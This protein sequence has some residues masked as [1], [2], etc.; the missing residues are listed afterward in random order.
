MVV[1]GSSAVTSGSSLAFSTNVRAVTMS[2]ISAPRH[3]AIADAGPVEKL[4][5]A[6]TRPSACSAKN[7]TSA[8]R[9]V[10]SS[11]PTRS[12]ARVRLASTPPSA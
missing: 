10:G 8:A 9:D 12:P 5:I 3:A 7:V 1:C 6:G 4:S 11:T 2:A